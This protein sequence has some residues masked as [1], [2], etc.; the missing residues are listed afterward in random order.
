MTINRIYQ[1]NKWTILFYFIILYFRCI[2]FSYFF[3]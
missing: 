3:T 2:L 1:K